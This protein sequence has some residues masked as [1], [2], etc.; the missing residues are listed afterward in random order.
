MATVNVQAVFK[1]E[2]LT[3]YLTDLVRRGKQIDAKDKTVAS[4][5][6][7]VVFRDVLDHFE[8]QEGPDG[9][10]TPWS[11]SYRRQMFRK[12]K[13]GNR[14]LQDTGRLRQNLQPQKYRVTKDGIVWFNNAKTK[15]GAP[16]AFMHDNDTEP[17][18]QLPRRSFMFLSDNALEQIEG[19][20]LKF[21]R[22]G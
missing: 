18:T 3:R 14:I 11:Q 2:N 21:L 19:Q 20:I 4:I 22:D 1:D 7:A 13:L 5:I 10:W 17:R 8:K 15:S 9:P 6:G 12:G 16:Y